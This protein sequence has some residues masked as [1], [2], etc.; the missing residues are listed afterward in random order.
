MD[1]AYYLD[2][3]SVTDRCYRYLV[4]THEIIGMTKLRGQS[5]VTRPCGTCRV[6][7]RWTLRRFEYQDKNDFVKDAV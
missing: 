6:C 3:G 5:E 7:D 2:T 4:V 1:I